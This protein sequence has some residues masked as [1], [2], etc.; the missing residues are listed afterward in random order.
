VPFSGRMT[1]ASPFEI[2]NV[3]AMPLLLWLVVDRSFQTQQECNYT[4]HLHHFSSPTKEKAR[5]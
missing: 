1:Q 3:R 2:T 4:Q 5:H